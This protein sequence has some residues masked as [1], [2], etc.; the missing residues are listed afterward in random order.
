[1]KERFTR[2]L[3]EQ[4]KNMTDR[5]LS[6]KI[7][8]AIIRVGKNTEFSENVLRDVINSLREEGYSKA[9][10]LAHLNIIDLEYRT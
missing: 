7:T 3:S 2:Y 5:E 1:M 8:A 9:E 6:E 4:Y 10:I